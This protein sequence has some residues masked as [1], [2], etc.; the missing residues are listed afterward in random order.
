MWFKMEDKILTRT[1]PRI[2]HQEEL[3][4]NDKILRHF[5]LSSQYGVSF[6]P[7]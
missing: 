6:L 7:Y 3:G 1:L 4:M 2:V 5:D